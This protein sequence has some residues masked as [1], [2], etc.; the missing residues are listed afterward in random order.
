MCKVSRKLIL[1]SS[2]FTRRANLAAALGAACIA[3]PAA[4]MPEDTFPQGRTRADVLSWLAGNS[5]LNP[6]SV[7]SMTDEL[8]A[9]VAVRQDGRGV[10]GSTRLTLRE[11]VINP[12]AA[13]AWGGRSMQLDLDL[14]CSRRRVMLGVR[15][16]YARPNLQGSVRIT[17]SDTAWTEAPHDTVIDDVARFA[18]APQPPTQLAAA[19]P[20]R[21]AE[22]MSLAGAT[23]ATTVTIAIPSATSVAVVATGDVTPPASPREAQ[24]APADQSVVMHN[25]FAAAEARGPALK[26]PQANPAARPVQ[27]AATPT[28]PPEF[29]VQIAAAA[30]ADLARDSWRALKAKVPDL[31]GPRTFAVEPVSAKGRTV[32]RALLL[33]FNSREEAAA[34][35]DAL[36]G[37]A[38]DCVLREMR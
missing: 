31:V 22:S 10:G 5:D 14:D 2:P 17:R 34:L 15:R 27:E 13:A 38:M 24:K 11:E 20:A 7:V 33:G 36:R 16:V 1:L 30:S 3:G 19:Q 21:P 29:A 8:V 23:A 28:R 18:C 37:Q 32:F 35:C 25:P 9:A 4:A 26:P 6:D 12:D